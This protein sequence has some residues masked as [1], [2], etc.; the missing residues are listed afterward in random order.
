MINKKSYN[1]YL[2]SI[3]PDVE[4]YFHAS[5][6]PIFDYG[7]SNPG[8]INNIKQ[9]A[10]INDNITSGSK[11]ILGDLGNT[12]KSGLS[13][14]A[15]SNGL[16]NTLK[17]N[18]SNFGALAGNAASSI[19]SGGNHSG[20][21]D[22]V[23]SIGSGAA[24]FISKANPVLGGIVG[25]A[26]G[27]VGGLVNGAFGSNINKAAV[28]NMKLQATKEN[29]LNFSASTNDNL[30]SQ[31]NYNYLGHINKSDVGSDGW[32]SNKASN[33]AN[34]LETQRI[35][36][37]R[38]ADLSYS[39]A[40]NNIEDRTNSNIMANYSAYGGSINRFD[41]G[42]NL[43]YDPDDIVNSLF[44]NMQ[45]EGDG[46]EFYNNLSTQNQSYNNQVTPSYSNAED[47]SPSNNIKNRISKWEGS[48]MQTNVPFNEELRRFKTVSPNLQYLSNNQ[49]DA[50]YSTYYNAPS[51]YQRE[52]VPLLRTLSPD[53]TAS[54]YMN[55]KNHITAGMTRKGMSG[56][57]KRRLAEQNIFLNGY[58][59]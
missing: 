53:S 28:N 59:Q 32:F 19:F 12:F 24:S 44:S 2:D 50:L 4:P 51:Q 40:A 6:G 18:I 13:S 5:G 21:G 29:N 9:I 23:S 22:S 33:L 36:A 39:N 17:N 49:R 41:S 34:K 56:L 10:P 30:L 58:T 26:S 14:S 55:I 52:I 15:I 1:N 11:G 3:Y 25:A 7:Q 37:N 54:D 48:T 16:S 45:I 42:G 47:W 27:V 46:T 8:N 38:S 31:S 35:E 20:V 43:G 57:A